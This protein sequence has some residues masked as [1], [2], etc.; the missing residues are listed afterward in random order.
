M[1][2]S[3]KRILAGVAVGVSFAAV[4]GCGTPAVVKPVANPLPGLT[5]AIQQAKSVIAQT[6]RQ[7][8]ADGANGVSL[9]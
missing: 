6:E 2:L 9:P 7:A 1:S 5:R 4:A 8:Q 3:I